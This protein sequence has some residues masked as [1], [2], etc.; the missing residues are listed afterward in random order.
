MMSHEVLAAAAAREHQTRRQD[1]ARRRLGDELRASR[2]AER[3]A[4]AARADGWADVVLRDGSAVL[5][6]P[7]TPADGPLLADGF[8]R[9]SPRSRRLRF[10]GPKK[11]LTPSELHRLTDIDHHDHEALGAVQQPGGQTERMRRMGRVDGL[12]LGVARYVRSTEDPLAADCAVTV[13][14]GWH[15][16]GLATALLTR[17]A[18]RARLAG[19]RRFT[20]QVA[21]DNTAMVGLLLRLG[22]DVELVRHDEL[23]LGFAVQLDGPTPG[24]S[25]QPGPGLIPAPRQP[26]FD[27]MLGMVLDLAPLDTAPLEP[28]GSS[29]GPARTLAP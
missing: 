26:R 29:T 2:A 5:I 14:D 20:G 25:A 6:R 27:S 1:A 19:I 7:V 21:L 8:A 12:G 24:T 11:M 9:L 18:D 3:A 16:R 10:L 13:V 4:R 15:R 23:T 22:A 28:A 17:L